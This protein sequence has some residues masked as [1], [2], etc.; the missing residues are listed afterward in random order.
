MSALK[1]DQPR[2]RHRDSRSGMYEAHPLMLL[3]FLCSQ[4]IK[5]DAANLITFGHHNTHWGISSRIKREMELPN[6]NRELN[7]DIVPSSKKDKMN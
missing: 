5:V 6:I 2:D 4:P 7:I 3:S 1:R